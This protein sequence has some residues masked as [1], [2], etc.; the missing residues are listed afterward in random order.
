MLLSKQCPQF[1]ES[2]RRLHT[3]PKWP[4]KLVALSVSGHIYVLSTETFD[5]DQFFQHD[6]SNSILFRSF[7]FSPESCTFA[8][9]R[10]NSDGTL[11]VRF[12]VENNSLFVNLC[13]LSSTALKEIASSRLCHGEVRPIY[14]LFHLVV[15][16]Y[17]IQGIIDITCSTSG[18][19][20]VLSKV[21]SFVNLRRINV[22]GSFQWHLEYLPAR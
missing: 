19:I 22:F 16:A 17:L 11:I 13:L 1:I 4:S 7:T 12:F 18:Y 15:N 8:S 14:L 3:L 5:I 10:L 9:R 2:I 6:T 21:L 20:M